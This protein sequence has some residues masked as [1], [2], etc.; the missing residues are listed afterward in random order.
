LPGKTVKN[1]GPAP[2]AKRQFLHYNSKYMRQCLSNLYINPL[3]LLQSAARQKHKIDKAMK[4]CKMQ[5]Q[6][7]GMAYHIGKGSV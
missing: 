4:L 3:F 6:E 7:R 2:V 5:G 1:G